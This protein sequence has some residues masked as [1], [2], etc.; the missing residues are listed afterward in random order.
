MA[1]PPTDTNGVRLAELMASLSLATDIGLGANWEN[2]ERSVLFAVPL[3]E[4]AGLTEEQVRDAFYL[5]LLKTVGCIGDDDF[6]PLTFGEDSGKWIAHLGGA[7]TAEAL[8]ALARNVARELP[9]PQRIARVV[10][11]VTRLAGMPAISRGHC[12][13]GRLLGDRFSLPQGVLRGLTQIFERWDGKGAPAKLKGEAIDVAVRVVQVAGD[14]QAAHLLLGDDGTIALLNRRSGR[15]YDPKVVELFTR[16]ARDLFHR[17]GVSSVH[18]AVL[19][20]EPGPALRLSGEKL[21]TAVRAMGEY[22]DMKSRYTRGHS[23]G[24]AALAVAAANRLGLPDGIALGRA[25]HLHDLGRVGVTLAVW[26]KPGTL[27]ETEWERVRMHTYFT[28]RVLARLSSLGPVATIAALAH[29]RLDGSGYHRRLPPG[30]IAMA[31]RVLAAGDAYHAMTEPRPHR[32]ALTADR[33]ADLLSADAVAGR[34]DHDAVRAVLAAAGRAA[35]DHPPAR[36]AR[37]TEREISVLRLL[38]RGLTNKEIASSLDISVKTAGHHVQ[39][40]FEKTGVT[41]RAAAGLFAMQ[42]GVLDPHS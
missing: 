19:Q 1:A 41:T 18:E 4:L 17:L 26:D 36:V 40:I 33:A 39:H 13:V 24:V 23:A 35:S 38:A 28:E 37:L 3:A 11:A 27:T 22:A 15:G 5:S 21:E 20:S 2:A 7:S 32:A 12:E 14:A 31:A 10:R 9:A 42:N 30:A 29:E 8:G 25:G 34:L 6:G 16:N